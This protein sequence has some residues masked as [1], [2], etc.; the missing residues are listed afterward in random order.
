MRP[1][2]VVVVTSLLDQHLGLLEC[3]EDLPFEQ[4]V[5][6]FPVEAFVAQDI[7]EPPFSFF[8]L[9]LPLMARK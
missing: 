1:D 8:G 6:K 7:E 2:G 9:R 5:P 4:L 3:V